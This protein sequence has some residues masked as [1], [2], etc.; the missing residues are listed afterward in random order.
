[1]TTKTMSQNQR[2]SSIR[3]ASAVQ[4]NDRGISANKCKIRIETSKQLDLIEWDK[5]KLYVLCIEDKWKIKVL[6]IYYALVFWL[7]NEC[8]LKTK[9][10]KIV[11]SKPPDRSRTHF[12]ILRKFIAFSPIR[13]IVI[14]LVVFAVE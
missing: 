1:M 2:K 9:L 6:I 4:K 5:N 11:F 7:I 10:F 3:C 12:N 13:I 14:V 8:L